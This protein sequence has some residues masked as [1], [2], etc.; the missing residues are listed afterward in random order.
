MRTGVMLTVGVVTMA[1]LA[2]ACSTTRTADLPAPAPLESASPGTTPSVTSPIAPGQE[3]PAPATPTPTEVPDKPPPVKPG[4]SRAIIK[5]ESIAADLSFTDVGGYPIYSPPKAVSIT[6]D[7]ITGSLSIG[8]D[9]LKEGTSKTSDTLGVSFTIL[10]GGH[11]FGAG[12]KGCRVTIERM[13]KKI[14]KGWFVCPEA[15]DSATE[16][17]VKVIASFEYK[18]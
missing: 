4:E 1:V 6:W 16:E 10:N 3:E 8:G 7:D 15:I 11:T 5:G 18:A 14:F 12:E 2:S 17:A 9:N 13:T